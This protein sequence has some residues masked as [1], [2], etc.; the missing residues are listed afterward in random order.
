MLKGI[1][2]NKDTIYVIADEKQRFYFTGFKSSFG[3]LVI[4]NDE[5]IYYTD[6]RYLSAVKERLKGTDVK[7]EEASSFEPVKKYIADGGFKKLAIDYTV[8][9]VS[10]YVDFKSTGLDVC[11]VSGELAQVMSI[12]TNDELNVIRESCRI[13]QESFYEVIKLLRTG[14]TEKEIATEFEHIMK[15]KGAEGV[16]FDLIIAFGENAAVPHHETDDTAL[17]EN[18]VVLMDFGCLYKGYCSDMTRT[19]FYGEPDEK[20]VADYNAVLDSAKNAENNVKDGMTGKV[21]DAFSRDVLGKAGLASY[22]THSLGHGIGVNIH[23]YPR[24]S[25]YADNVLKNN[26]VFSIE[27]GIYKDGLYG[28]RIEDTVA[29]IDGK[30]ERF[31]TDDKS[32]I[33]IDIKK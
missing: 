21:A 33:K 6:L 4:T 22:F 23:E 26:M 14:I 29:L 11:D 16:S 7:V 1:K 27:P 12:K 32:L 20:F 13:A 8:T 10:D 30:V 19:V 5:N 18:Q 2:P 3:Y 9:F 25:M 24:L 31:M 15:K 17:C 28:I